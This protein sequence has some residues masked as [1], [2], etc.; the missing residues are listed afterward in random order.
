VVVRKLLERP[1]LLKNGSG[2]VHQTFAC[3]LSC[4]I[5]RSWFISEA[6]ANGL[7]CD[8]IASA[9]CYCART[10]HAL[11]SRSVCSIQAVDMKPHRF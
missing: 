9:F 5:N 8:S 2:G 11:D 7:C 1:S 4:V 6:R 10:E 3:I